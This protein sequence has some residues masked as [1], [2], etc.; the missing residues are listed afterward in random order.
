MAQDY[1]HSGCSIVIF[2]YLPGHHGNRSRLGVARD[3]RSVAG[4]VFLK[5]IMEMSGILCS[6]HW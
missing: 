2:L 6:V 3:T 4:P 1:H 5:R